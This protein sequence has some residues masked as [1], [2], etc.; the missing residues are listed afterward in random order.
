[1]APYARLQVAH[2]NPIIDSR[3]AKSIVAL[4][5]EFKGVRAAERKLSTAPDDPEANLSVGRF[6][7]RWG[8]RPTTGTG[9]GLFQAPDIGSRSGPLVRNAQ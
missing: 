5:K 3:L 9:S 8:G 6:S 2:Y 4:E 7:W 1:M